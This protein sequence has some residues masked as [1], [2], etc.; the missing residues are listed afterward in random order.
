MLLQPKADET[1]LIAYYLEHHNTA[2][3]S[4]FNSKLPLIEATI[5]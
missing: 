1:N 4:T 2:F 3:E 5:V